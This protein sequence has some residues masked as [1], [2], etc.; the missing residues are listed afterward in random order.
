MNSVSLKAFRHCLI[1]L[2]LLCSSSVPAG[3]APLWSANHDA[4]FI[5]GF[6]RSYS[7]IQGYPPSSSH[8]RASLD[9]VRRYYSE[10]AAAGDDLN[11]TI[12]YA[13]SSCVKILAQNSHQESGASSSPG[14]RT[15][16]S[17]SA[18]TTLSAPE[19]IAPPSRP[20]QGSTN[21]ATAQL[22]E[23][24]RQ[25]SA[26]QAKGDYAQAVIVSQQILQIYE[27]ELGSEHRLTATPLNNLAGLYYSQ[28]RYR[29]AEPSISV[30]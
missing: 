23:M 24:I 19:P 25:A 4:S 9:C 14:L 8:I 10:A 12:K 26:L 29:E 16:A 2:G 5:Q 21:N 30:H 20:G 27:K 3:A 7:T 1:G 11:A 13:M 17:R 6:V 15:P 28:G 22:Q 18:G